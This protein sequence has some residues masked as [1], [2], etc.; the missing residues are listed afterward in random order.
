MASSSTKRAL[1][2]RPKT[3]STRFCSH[4]SMSASRAKPESARSFH[5]RPARPDLMHDARNFLDRPGTRIDVGAAQFRREQVPAAEDI[6][7]QGAVAIIV[8]VEE[9]AFLMPVD[10][11][12]KS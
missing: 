8:A 1:R 5:P 10:R 3:K 11:D 9:A 7:R 12:R 2:A 4:Q 6:E